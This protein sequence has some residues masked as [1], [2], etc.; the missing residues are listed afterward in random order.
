MLSASLFTALGYLEMHTLQHQLFTRKFQN[1]LKHTTHLL[2]M[3]TNSASCRNIVNVLKA[4]KL[5]YEA[6]GF[7]RL[8]DSTAGTHHAYRKYTLNRL[9]ARIT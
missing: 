9:N 4:Y 8:A 5:P 2:P 1:K 3:N 7:A 6:H